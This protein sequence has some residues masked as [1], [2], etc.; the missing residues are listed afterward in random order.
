MKRILIA[1]LAMG[2]YGS[3]TAD[4]MGPVDENGVRVLDEAM[5]PEE[6]AV[7]YTPHRDAAKAALAL[8]Q[9][10]K[11]AQEYELAGKATAF[12]WVRARHFAN[13]AF[14]LARSGDRCKES[15]KWYDEA[16][17]VQILAEEKDSGGDKWA[18]SRAQ[19]RR[20]IEWGLYD[21][22]CGSKQKGGK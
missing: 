18:K 19:T 20:D 6:K 14:A 13:K 21:S 22:A 8:K 17:R 16:L 11:A 1:V 3:A 15:I 12:A 7:K 9:F 4:F 10:D 2:L 5:T